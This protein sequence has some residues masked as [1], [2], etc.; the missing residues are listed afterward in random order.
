MAAKPGEDCSHEADLC[1]GYLSAMKGLLRKIKDSYPPK[2]Q[3]SCDAFQDLIVKP[4]GSNK[5]PFLLD[6][7]S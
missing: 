7:L 3:A 6:A 5:Q 2:A 1:A 4:R